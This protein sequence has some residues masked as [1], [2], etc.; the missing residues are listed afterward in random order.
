MTNITS[1]YADIVL[2]V[3]ESKK[4]IK[5]VRNIA[6]GLLAVVILLLIIVIFGFFTARDRAVLFSPSQKL[7]F[8]GNTRTYRAYVPKNI[9]SNPKMI[10]AFHGL[11]SDGRQMAY[12]SALHN[13]TDTNTIV[14]YPDATK[15]IKPGIRPG[16]NSG[17]CCGSGL[18]D[19]VDDIGYVK[20]LVDQLSK[21][22]SVN[23]DNIYATGF[24]SGA[25]LVQRIATDE[26]RLFAGYVSVAGNIGT[27]GNELK[28]SHPVPIL[29]IHGQQD[30]I[31][32][33]DGGEGG[34]DPKLMWGNFDKTVKTWEIINDCK[35]SRINDQSDT[36]TTTYKA[37]EMPLKTIV[38]K[39]KGHIWPDWRL[40]NLW[41]KNPN[42]NKEIIDF[43][44]S[45]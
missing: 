29:H 25:M 28:P 20:A 41:H 18:V 32:P 21:K 34:S 17:F 24:S 4:Y 3:L 11:G 23:S 33:Y 9:S 39:N 43:L 8:G 10:F 26:P 14:V 42:G 12:F 1:I 31:V 37:C 35:D 44:N 30:N 22:Y 27:V 45:L 5:V 2:R 38:Y 7:D 15:S 6:M 40:G 16:W 19:K 13:S 36:I